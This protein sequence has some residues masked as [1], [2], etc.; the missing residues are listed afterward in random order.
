MLDGGLC[1]APSIGLYPQGTPD[2]LVQE[3]VHFLLPGQLR[4]LQDSTLGSLLF[5]ELNLPGEGKGR[6]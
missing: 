5:Q 2:Y 3:L 4:L 1:A 6:Q